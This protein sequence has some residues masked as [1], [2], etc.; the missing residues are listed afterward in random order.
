VL[1]ITGL[2][3][4]VVEVMVISPL[5][6]KVLVNDLIKLTPVLNTTLVALPG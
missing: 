6:E 5:K 3:A 2:L 1:S 4:K